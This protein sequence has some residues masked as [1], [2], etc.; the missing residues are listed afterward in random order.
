MRG[1]LINVFTAELAQLDTSATAAGPPGYDPVF[2][3]PKVSYDSTGRRESGRKEKLV[4]L[5]CQVETGTFETLRMT[6]TGN[7]PAS[8]ITLVFHFKDLEQCG[9]VD[10][11]HRPT[12]RVNDRLSAILDRA[13]EI[14]QQAFPY[15]PGLFAT[16]VTPS[17]FGF[18][19]NVNLIVMRFGTRA[20]AKTE[21]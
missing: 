20:Q 13:G 2:K 5:P 17:G 8:Q 14:V 1:R 3:E 15:P 10:D 6:P 16:E 4:R 18:G 19:G 9:L 11:K 12:L 21:G 7:A